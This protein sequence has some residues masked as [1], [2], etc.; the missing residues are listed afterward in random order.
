MIEA[1]VQ[2]PQVG[3][4]CTHPIQYQVPIWKALANSGVATK[5]F[6]MTEANAKP[7]QSE[8]FGAAVAWD[9]PL[10]D[11][12]ESAILS[13]SRSPNDLNCNA[14]I[15]ACQKFIAGNFDTVVVN[16]YTHLFEPLLSLIARAKGIN[17][18]M[19][20]EFSE[21]RKTSTLKR[22]MRRFYLRQIY[23]LVNAFCYIGTDA[24]RH[25]ISHGVPASRMFFS[26]YCV[27]TELLDLQDRAFDRSACR[28][29][30]GVQDDQIVLLSSGKLIKRKDP[31]LV[32]RA[33]DLLPEQLKSRIR[34]LIMGDGPLKAELE[35]SGRKLL[36]SRVELL[37]FVNQSSIGKYFK[38]AD[39]FVLG[40]SFETWGLVVN[41]AMQFGL[42][43]VVSDAAGCVRDL[44]IEGRTGF[45][46][47]SQ[48]DVDCA[49]KLS[50]LLQDGNRRRSMGAEAK[51]HIQG[52]T[53]Y[54][55]ARGLLE[56]IRS[57]NSQRVTS[58]N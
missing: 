52:Y 19:R 34:L 39:M 21:M 29:A 24:R 13:Q 3:I 48:C 35:Q 42:P 50:I 28:A 12:Y 1:K 14:A 32:I 47:K 9:V 5:V 23:S 38:A 18:V 56:A 37:G 45:S 58:V 20:G 17:V 53:S 22:S 15:R 33:I 16:G 40:S 7:T 44:V 55:S 51:C 54:E 49:E 43:V 36:G 2:R 41:E 8:E 31:L 11:G 10:F 25:L 4:F 46:F 26:P 6:Y 57:E 30:L 27:D